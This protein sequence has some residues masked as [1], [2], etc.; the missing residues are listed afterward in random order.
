MTIVIQILK[1]DK[2]VHF[3]NRL[4]PTGILA[5]FFEGVDVE[6]HLLVLDNKEMKTNLNNNLKV[7]V[8]K[9]ISV[10]MKQT[11]Q[12]DMMRKISNRLEVPKSLDSCLKE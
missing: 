8:M 12:M 4:L 9:I 10:M 3:L 11:G 5:Q 6:D 2:Y 1:I 7:V